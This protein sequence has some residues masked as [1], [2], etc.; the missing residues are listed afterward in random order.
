MLDTYFIVVGFASNMP[1]S[2]SVSSEENLIERYKDARVD[3]L[4]DLKWSGGSI[5]MDNII[6]VYKTS[7]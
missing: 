5:R 4:K 2:I 6:G 3:L 7:L 1:Y